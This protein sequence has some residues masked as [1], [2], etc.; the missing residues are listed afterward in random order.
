[1]AHLRRGIYTSLDHDEVQ[2]EDEY[3][4]SP[5]ENDMARWVRVSRAFSTPALR[6]LWAAPPSLAPLWSLLAPKTTSSGR[7]ADLSEQI[8]KSQLWNEPDRWER[9]LSYAPLVQKVHLRSKSLE[10]QL[11]RALVEHNGGSTILPSLRNQPEGRQAV[12]GSVSPSTGEARWASYARPPDHAGRRHR[13]ARD[14]GC[15]APRGGA[16]SR[17]V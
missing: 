17:D 7:S 5:H 9:F 6:L 4:Y 11:V 10:L 3:L 13:A 1:M 14:G 12:V 16:L 2:P 15:F 8:L